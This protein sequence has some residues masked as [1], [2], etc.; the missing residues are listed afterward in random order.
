V[1]D[2][3]AS[4]RS[5]KAPVAA[6][7]SLL[8]VAL[9]GCA[10]LVHTALAPL[11]RRRTCVR[12]EGLLAQGQRWQDALLIERG[13]LRLCFVRRDGREFNKN[14]F[15]EGALICPLTPAMCG[16][17]SLFAINA[18]DA[19]AVWRADAAALRRV[20]DDHGA[21]LPLQR[22]LLERLITHK[23]QREHDLL[24]LDGRSRYDAFCRREPQLAERV[25]LGQLATYLGLTDVSLSRI[26]RQRR[27][28]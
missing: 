17:P 1:A 14:F 22:L 9:P 10:A 4:A 23:L 16:E 13:L 27:P 7:E 26:R 21:W 11:F 12:G 5:A 24:T 8:A 3:D 25:P 18:L 28:G 15:S 6:I 19:G 2:V 20:L